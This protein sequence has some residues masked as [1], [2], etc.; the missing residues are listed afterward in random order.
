MVS[1]L[2]MENTVKVHTI[3]NKVFPQ[4]HQASIQAPARHKDSSLDNNTAH[5]AAAAC[6]DRHKLK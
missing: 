1:L 3:C 2:I 5:G 6:I 4:F